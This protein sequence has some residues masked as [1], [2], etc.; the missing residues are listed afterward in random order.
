MCE[1]RYMLA[2]HCY[3]A[4][5]TRDKTMFNVYV[6]VSIILLQSHHR[7]TQ[8]LVVVSAD[9]SVLNHLIIALYILYCYV[10]W[11][12]N[13]LDLVDIKGNMKYCIMMHNAI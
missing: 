7:L 9:D 10:P 6:A 1:F 5:H 8:Q 4:L 12:L 3:K 11:L 2:T 13:I